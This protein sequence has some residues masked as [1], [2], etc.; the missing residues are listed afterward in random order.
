MQPHLLSD[1]LESLGNHSEGV[2][3]QF[4]FEITWLVNIL[5]TNRSG[6]FFSSLFSPIYC[7]SC[8]TIFIASVELASV[9]QENTDSLIK[10]LIATI[11]YQGCQF[12]INVCIYAHIYR[13]LKTNMQP[14]FTAMIKQQGSTA[15][16]VVNCQNNCC[17]R[18]LEFPL[19]RLSLVQAMGLITLIHTLF[20]QRN[21]TKKNTKL[22]MIPNFVSRSVQS[23]T[24]IP[25]AVDFRNLT[26][27]IP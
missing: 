14:Q 12:K 11:K 6:S 4:P 9:L 23:I 22:Y 15:L 8:R 3:I 2:G 5:V 10:M 18:Q 16:L 27:R 24:Q 21:Q 1:W 25:E 13:T 20:L 7:F 26:R 17:R 19:T